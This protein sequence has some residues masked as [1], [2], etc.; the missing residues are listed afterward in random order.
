MKVS[1]SMYGK[2]RMQNTEH[3]RR[4]WHATV[5]DGRKYN[6][7]V[8]GLVSNYQQKPRKQTQQVKPV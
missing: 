2:S 1:L 3:G 7:V 4:L 8:K 5:T 6:E